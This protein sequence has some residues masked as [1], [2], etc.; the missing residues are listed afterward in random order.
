MIRNRK[1][2]W[3]LSAGI[4]L[5]FLFQLLSIGIAEPRGYSLLYDWMA[6]A[7]N[8]VIVI[9]ILFLY[10]Q[11][12]YVRWAVRMAAVILIVST[13]TFFLFKGD[14]HLVV[15]QSEDRRH[16]V[17]LKEYSEMKQ[18]TIS[19]KRIAW[20]FGK[21]TGI[22]T[23]SSDY[24][25]IERDTYK[26]EW[27]HGDTAVITYQASEEK[28]SLE[29]EVVNFRPSSYVSYQ[30]AVV[31]LMGKWVDVDQPENFLLAEGSQFV[32]ARDGELFYY[33]AEDAEQHGIYAVTLKGME[34]NPSLTIVLSPEA[35]FGDDNLI[36]GSITIHPVTLDPADGAIY[37]RE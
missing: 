23:G 34:Q 29:Q 10:I 26:V 4:F 33:R 15:E 19:L 13:T 3:F 32:Y 6:Y 31:G 22:L 11:N 2:K 12:L 20:I 5:L 16:E 36:S 25:T 30:N 1:I 14:V 8:Y 9:M 28:D 27:H 24:K 35:E 7:V 37:E 21:Q 17:I 18:E